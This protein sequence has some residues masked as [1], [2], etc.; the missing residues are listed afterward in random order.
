MKFKAKFTFLAIHTLIQ[1]LLEFTS[2]EGCS[3]R[4][5]NPGLAWI[6]ILVLWYKIN[7]ASLTLKQVQISGLFCE[8]YWLILIKMGFKTFQFLVIK[9]NECIRITKFKLWTLQSV[10]LVALIAIR[11]TWFS[12]LKD[13]M[14]S[15]QAF[16]CTRKNRKYT[17]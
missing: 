17:I 8:T 10:Y 9:Q 15:S 1:G 2:M 11:R 3:G 13:R 14:I 5:S 6:H 16:L 4:S 12:R 7:L